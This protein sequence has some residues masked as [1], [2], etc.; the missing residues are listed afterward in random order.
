MKPLQ[1]WWK[2]S[3]KITFSIVFG[4][5][6][7]VGCLKLDKDFGWHLMSGNYIVHHGI[8][9]T[10]I[11]TYT[12]QSFAWIN[13]EWLNDVL[14]YMLYISGGLGLLAVV[15]AV[16]GA[17]AMWLVG[18]RHEA[19]AVLLA[20]VAIVPFAGV[21]PIVW[22]LL[23]LATSIFI[24][25][26]QK[27]W[28]WLP[29]VFAVWANL[30]GG[31]AL[32]LI[33][34]AYAALRRRSLW[35]GMVTLIAFVATALNPYGFGV[36][37][38]I[39]RTLGDSSLH[40]TIGEW[41]SFDVIYTVWPLGVVWLA[42]FVV[43]SAKHI[44]EYARFDVAMLV[45]GL[46]SVRNWPLFG[47]FAIE[48]TSDYVRRIEKLLPKNLDHPRR[49]V[50][51]GLVGGLAAFAVGCFAVACYSIAHER[52]QFPAQAVTYLRQYPCQGQLFAYYDYGGYLI[53]QLPNRAVYID[54]RMPSWQKSDGGS[55]MQD[56]LR[57]G[58]DD[59]FRRQ[60]FK[61][62]T[63]HCVLIPTDDSLVSHLKADQW[64]VVWADHDNILLVH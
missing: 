6:L 39:F 52:Q 31:F 14:V 13:H 12:A 5:F 28:W 43:F 55:Y 25:R 33:Y 36:Y 15:W 34:I 60:Q 62:Y 51:Y 26:Q 7:V 37:T 24:V 38:E 22:T 54:G 40:Q 41:S 63:I 1:Y 17:L 9:A 27:L 11:F 56:Y 23:G 2:L 8:P 47:L 57:I 61:K 46:S 45:A 50:I 16:L 48:R 4:M 10:D 18:R 44:R 3:P 59:A 21:R 35:L 20:A 32:G 64:R 49:A 30:H 42:G 29:I 53:W 58:T 19:G